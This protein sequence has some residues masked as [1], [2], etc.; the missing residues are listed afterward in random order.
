MCVVA[1]DAPIP[2]G[3]ANYAYGTKRFFMSADEAAAFFNS[4][5]TPAQ[6]ATHTANG[7]T[8]QDDPDAS[9]DST[10]ASYIAWQ[11]PGASS[12]LPGYGFARLR[13]PIVSHLNVYNVNP[14]P[15]GP[16]AIDPAHPLYQSLRA[17]VL[18]LLDQQMQFESNLSGWPVYET[19]ETFAG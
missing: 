16:T 6:Q 18:D 13:G 1:D 10:K 2:P 19:P 15:D 7:L 3:N 17:G 8:F 14:P 4:Q 12:T 11:P 5:P 9:T